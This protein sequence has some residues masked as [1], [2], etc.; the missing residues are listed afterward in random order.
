MTKM[1]PSSQDQA[2]HISKLKHALD[3][4][5]HKRR[6]SELHMHQTLKCAEDLKMQLLKK[7]EKVKNLKAERENLKTEIIKMK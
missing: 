2:A 4:S 1:E 3:Q 5:E 7:I 6:E